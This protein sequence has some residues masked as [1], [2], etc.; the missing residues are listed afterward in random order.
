MAANG[1]AD[2]KVKYSPV[3]SSGIDPPDVNVKVGNAATGS[4]G[5]EAGHDT[6]KGLARL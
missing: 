3:K 5:F 2:V 1:E 6:I 4:F